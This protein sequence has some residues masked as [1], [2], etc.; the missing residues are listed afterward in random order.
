MGP[1]YQQQLVAAVSSHDKYDIK[2]V[3]TI[4]LPIL[5]LSE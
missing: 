2:Y 4:A 5:D 3:G 1:L